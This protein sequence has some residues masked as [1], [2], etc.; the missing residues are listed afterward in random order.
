MHKEI[1]DSKEPSKE[2]F[3]KAKERV[4]LKPTA[5]LDE[6]IKVKGYDFEK[7]F[8]IDAFLDSYFTTGFQATDLRLAIEICREM[9]KDNATIFF[10]FTSNMVSCGLREIIAYL[11]K[12]KLIHVLVTTAGGIEEDIIKTK[13]SFVIGSYHTPGNVLLDQGINRTGNL[14]IPNDRY[15]ELHRLLEPFF[16]RLYHQQKQTGKIINTKDFIFELGKE[17]KDENSIYYWTTKHNIP[18]FCPALTDGAIGDALYF[19]KKKYPDF[20]I[21]MADDIVAITDIALNAEKTGIIALG[22]SMPKHHIANANLFREGAD[23]AV[24]ITT[25]AEYEG[26]NAGANIEEAKSWG[27]VKS[28]APNVKV[29]GEASILFPLLVAGAFR[30]ELDL[31]HTKSIWT[32]IKDKEL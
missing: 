7:P 22:G 27:K 5:T 12:H 30:K 16:M 21:D 29:N 9:R 3:E 23:Y 31:D 13:K 19:F 18:V 20:K 14:F 10:G 24:Y 1:V 25:A 15:L 17:V 2:K 4:F 28:N 26:S 6:W 11:V 8:A 32:E